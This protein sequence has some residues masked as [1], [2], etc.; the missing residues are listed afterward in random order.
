[1]SQLYVKDRVFFISDI[2]RM[3]KKLTHLF[4]LH[5]SV[6]FNLDPFGLA[7][8]IYR[9]NSRIVWNMKIIS[10]LQRSNL[11]TS[12]DHSSGFPSLPFCLVFGC[13]IGIIRVL[14]PPFMSHVVACHLLCMVHLACVKLLIQSRISKGLTIS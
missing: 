11:I 7:N 13:I 2:G 5:C 8:A 4:L 10:I 14:V 12:I 1:M 3:I 6:S 9:M